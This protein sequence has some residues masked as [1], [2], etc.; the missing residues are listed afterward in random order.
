MGAFSDTF[1]ATQILYFE[2]LVTQY[3]AAIT[4]LASGTVKSHTISTGQTSQSF[5]KK[6]EISLQKS[7][8]WALSQLEIWTYRRDG[9]GNT[10][11]RSY[12]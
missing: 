4:A 6:D 12:Q 11:V 1:I 9:G 10:Y 8:E 5:T 7:L 2:G 3:Q